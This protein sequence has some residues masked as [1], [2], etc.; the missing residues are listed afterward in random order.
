M[1][2]RSILTAMFTLTALIG[3]GSAALASSDHKAQPD[4]VKEIFDQSAKQPPI[5]SEPI[6]ADRPSLI[7]L[8]HASMAGALGLAYVIIRRRI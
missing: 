2:S 5:H 7:P 3:L 1:F 6:Q 4:R 8:P